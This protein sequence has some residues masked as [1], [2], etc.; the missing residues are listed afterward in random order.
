VKTYQ[1]HLYETKAS[2]HPVVITAPQD[3]MDKIVYLPSWLSEHCPNGEYQA[4]CHPDD[5]LTDPNH[6]TVYF[7]EKYET[8][9]L[10]SLR[11]S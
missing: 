1:G 4:W 10:F 3:F 8:A 6:R 9:V 7:F 5:E 2:W 11:W